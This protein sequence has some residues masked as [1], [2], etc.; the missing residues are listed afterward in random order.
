MWRRHSLQMWS[1][2]VEAAAAPIL[3]FFWSR[4]QQEAI[5]E[6]HLEVWGDLL[7]GK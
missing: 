7:Q 1:R 5:D 2:V 3:S 4:V 6:A